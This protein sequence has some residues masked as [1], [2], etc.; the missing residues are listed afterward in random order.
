MQNLSDSS[1]KPWDSRQKR[2][3]MDR[4]SFDH[5]SEP[6]G[7]ETADAGAPTP[8]PTPEP[9]PTTARRAGKAGGAGRDEHLDQMEL[10]GGAAPVEHGSAATIRPVAGG[11]HRGALI[12]TRVAQ[13]ANGVVARN[14][15]QTLTYRPNPDFSGTDRFDYTLM[16]DAG[17]VFSATVTVSVSLEWP[18][19]ET[20]TETLADAP[21]EPSQAVEPALAPEPE[22][23]T[24]SVAETVRQS[25]LVEAIRSSDQADMPGALAIGAARGLDKAAGE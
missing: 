23:V 11:P 16:D 8:A 6:A 12:V 17:T 1:I 19:T 14:A 13:P 25:E 3:D 9:A 10:F 15:D 21:A 2:R 4:E 18:Q 22:P 20:P 5:E 7:T 24:E